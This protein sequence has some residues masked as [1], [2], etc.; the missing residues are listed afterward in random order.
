MRM[1]KL[2]AF[3]PLLAMLACAAGHKNT[4]VERDIIPGWKLNYEHL[5]ILNAAFDQRDTT[6]QYALH[7]VEDPMLTANMIITT[8]RFAWEDDEYEISESDSFIKAKSTIV[9]T[10]EISYYKVLNYTIYSKDDSFVMEVE[11]VNSFD[12][13]VQFLVRAAGDGIIVDTFESGGIIDDISES[14]EIARKVYDKLPAQYGCSNNQL[15]SL[16]HGDEFLYCTFGMDSLRIATFS[17]KAT[18]EDG[19]LKIINKQER[20]ARTEIHLNRDLE[21]IYMASEGLKFRDCGV[22]AA[23]AEREKR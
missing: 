2:V 23:L 22:D 14:G 10:G 11:K 4:A 12:G 6:R 16:A 3:L 13:E 19:I 1:L 15:G 18:R 7:S 5:G 9:E 21:V 20:G 17:N 8:W